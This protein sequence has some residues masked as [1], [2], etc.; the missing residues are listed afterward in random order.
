MNTIGK[1]LIGILGAGAVALSAGAPAF[2]RDAHV[3]YRGDTPREAIQ[4]CTRAAE[5]TADRH[6]R[7]HAKVTNVR[8]VERE[9]GGFDVKGRVEVRNAKSARYGAYESG[10][11]TCQVRYGRIASLDFQGIRGL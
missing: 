1:T 9:R 11:F 10:R 6:S 2:A 3:G 4:I 5:R 8:N 7:G